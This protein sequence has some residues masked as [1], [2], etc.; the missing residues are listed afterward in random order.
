[1]KNEK[2]DSLPKEDYRF[3]YIMPKEK[4]YYKII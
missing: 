2:T 3:Y 4:T 1:M